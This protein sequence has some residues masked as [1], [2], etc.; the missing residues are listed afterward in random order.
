MFNLNQVQMKKLLAFLFA[1]SLV[2]FTE[3]QVNPPPEREPL[4]VNQSDLFPSVPVIAIASQSMIV[5]M[6]TIN[7]TADLQYAQISNTSYATELHSPSKVPKSGN[8]QVTTIYS[9]SKTI[10]I[11]TAASTPVQ[12]QPSRSTYYR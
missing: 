5:S 9:N 11:T 12:Y 6:N 1:I 2:S 10:G 3:A 8:L 4:R 7:V